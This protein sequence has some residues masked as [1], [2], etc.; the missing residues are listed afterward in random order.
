VLEEG[1]WWEKG[2]EVLEDKEWT[3]KGDRGRDVE[4]IEA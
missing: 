1:K 3:F 2:S 4:K